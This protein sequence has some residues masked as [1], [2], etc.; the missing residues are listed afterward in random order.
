MCRTLLLSMLA[1]LV[2]TISYLP[3]SQLYPC[4]SI[5]CHGPSLPDFAVSITVCPASCKANR[6][7][8]FGLLP[9]STVKEVCRLA[10]DTLC[11]ILHL[12]VASNTYF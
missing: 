12:T 6:C 1:R 8:P 11:S 4:A 2:S 7:S 10:A 5:E 3:L 9:K